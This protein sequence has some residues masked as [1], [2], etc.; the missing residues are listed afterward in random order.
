MKY[1]LYKACSIWCYTHK[2]FE[3]CNKWSNHNDKSYYNIIQSA[4]LNEQI[5][6]K[7]G[8]VEVLIIP[9]YGIIALDRVLDKRLERIV[10]ESAYKLLRSEGICIEAS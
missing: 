10:I 4:L 2:T 7:I 1:T 8:N 6:K 9:K 5:I 3:Y